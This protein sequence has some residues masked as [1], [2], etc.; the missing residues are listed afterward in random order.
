MAQ[1][2]PQ[3]DRIG[4]LIL[5]FQSPPLLVKSLGPWC[6]VPAALADTNAPLFPLPWSKEACWASNSTF[7][8]A[9]R[10]VCKQDLV[11]QV[12]SSMSL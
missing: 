1:E 10:H 5:H 12:G 6:F 2:G 8:K 4:T 9:E 3:P 7:L 11:Q